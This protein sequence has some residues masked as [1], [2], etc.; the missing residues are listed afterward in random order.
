MQE[1]KKTTRKL[2]IDTDQS[3]TMYFSHKRVNQIKTSI[4]I[5]YV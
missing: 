5:E 2:K 4:L 3:E 1:L